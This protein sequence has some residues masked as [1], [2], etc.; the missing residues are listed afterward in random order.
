M[1]DPPTGSHGYT[2][3]FIDFENLYYHLTMQSVDYPEISDAVFD[4][5]RRLRTHLETELDLQPII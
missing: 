2:A 4:L 5:L 1:T 3:V